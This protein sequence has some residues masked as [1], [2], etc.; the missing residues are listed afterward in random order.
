MTKLALLQLGLILLGGFGASLLI[1]T[2]IAYRARRR[3]PNELS[4]VLM[5]IGWLALLVG[6]IV[7]VIAALAPLLEIFGRNLI[8]PLA[9]ILNAA[10]CLA[11]FYSA[12]RARQRFDR[13]RMLLWSIAA[14]DQRQMPL[15]S[16]ARTVAWEH[17]N[18]FGAYCERVADDLDRGK[19]VGDALRIDDAG[20]YVATRIGQQYNCL[21]K[22]LQHWLRLPTSA[23]SIL[24]YNYFALVLNV[25]ACI[26][27]LIVVQLMPVLYQLRWEFGLNASPA[28]LSRVTY[29]VTG[30]LIWFLP[31]FAAP[32]LLAV[33]I[34]LLQFGWLG[35]LLPDFGLGKLALPA[36]HA[37]VLDS[38][39]MGVEAGVPVG[40]ILGLLATVYP[41]KH[42]RTRLSLAAGQ[43]AM[44]K[45]WIVTLADLRMLTIA[46]RDMLDSAERAGN[47]SWAL[48]ELGNR[49]RRRLES[50]LRLLDTILFPA[51]TLAVAGLV[52]ILAIGMFSDL[53]ALLRVVA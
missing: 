36:D 38:L 3:S 9:F 2:R 37:R 6:F 39:A 15:G 28:S 40:E 1:A 33:L 51:A 7:P 41:K 49:K 29:F 45:P 25:L 11:V 48:A 44:G 13:L 19:A 31:V 32:M 14:A 47:L 43:H 27:L 35:R 46:E 18:R 30:N 20:A 53:N 17:C 52:A 23:V 16:A 8:L 26:G 22:C 24:R 42:M 12:M 5:F 50:Q 21:S 34:T 10:V 4:A